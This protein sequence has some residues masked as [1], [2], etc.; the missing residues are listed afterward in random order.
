VSLSQFELGLICGIAGSIVA[1][2][3]VG[4]CL[5]AADAVS[6]RRAEEFDP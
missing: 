3:L 6:R 4:I 1:F 5:L 2:L